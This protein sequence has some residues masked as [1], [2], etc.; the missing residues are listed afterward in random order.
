VSNTAQCPPKGW[1]WGA[2]PENYPE[3]CQ[4]KPQPKPKWDFG[5]G[6][7]FVSGSP[8]GTKIAELFTAD[9]Y[10]KNSQ[11]SIGPMIQLVP[12]G[13]FT[14]V[15]GALVGR[16]HQAIFHHDQVIVKLVPFI[17]LGGL[18]SE[19]KRPIG[20]TEGASEIRTVC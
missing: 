10:L 7:G 18:Y 6:P 14:Q 9:Y 2:Y 13:D 5:A 16:Y 12:P 17:G 19:V 1:G 3:E 11:A 15:A 20:R 8:N 4:P